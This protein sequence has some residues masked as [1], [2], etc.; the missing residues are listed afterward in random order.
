MKFMECGL[1]FLLISLSGCI[2]KPFQPAP[3]EFKL[4]IKSGASED[5]VKEVM[6]LCGYP[7]I[8]GFAGTKASVEK[9][10]SVEECMFRKGFQYRDGWKGKCSE[11]NRAPLMACGEQVSPKN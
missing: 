1:I 2:N 6:L 10:T 8:A 5:D 9:T 3:A 11:R 7:N 4:W